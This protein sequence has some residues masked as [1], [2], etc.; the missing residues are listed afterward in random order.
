M[1]L[2]IQTAI[3]EM[4]GVFE[5]SAISPQENICTAWFKGKPGFVVQGKDVNDAV[6]ELQKSALAFFEY[7]K[8]CI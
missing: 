7:Q 6:E 3:G 2:K 5:T 4:T 1:E 8:E